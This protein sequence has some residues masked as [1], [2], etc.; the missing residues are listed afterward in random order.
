MTDSFE[1]M[2]RRRLQ[3]LATAVPVDLP[4][5]ARMVAL[6]VVHRGPT[7]RGLAP[8]A[9]A[10]S[11]ALVLVAAFGAGLAATG[12]SGYWAPGASGLIDPTA[13]DGPPTAATPS[14]H[15]SPGSN[16]GE[17]S[18]D[19]SGDFEFSL[20]SDKSSY[21]ADEVISI[22]AT[23]VHRGPA[24]SIELCY[25]Q[26]VMGFGIREKINGGIDL[27]PVWLAYLTSPEHLT[28]LRD[29]PFTEPFWKSAGYS[30]DDPAA[31]SFRAF[32]RDPIL[33]LPSGTWHVYAEE[34]F[35]VCDG[36]NQHVPLLHDAE[37]TVVVH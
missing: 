8:S 10:A 26:A 16:R 14:H 34:H 2:L 17:V 36:S 28:L 7:S 27:S 31:E 37:L 24:A 25:Q 21:V 11:L 3:V 19:P 18:T 12:L 6:E 4:P 35:S 23:L 20:S 5:E 32:A 9:L 30:E 33:R 22:T 15:S 29:V 13:T 1:L